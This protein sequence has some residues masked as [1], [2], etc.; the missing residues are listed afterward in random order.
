MSAI[1][2]EMEMELENELA[3]ERYEHETEAY[4]QEFETESELEGEFES[5]SENESEME[6][7]AF[8]NHLAA[9]ADR[10]GR[11]Q[12]LRRIGLAAARQALRSYRKS[13]PPAIEGEGEFE[14][15]FFEMEAEFNPL[16]AAHA[17]AVMEHLGHEAAAAETEE[18][19]AEQFLP[20]VPLA[21]KFVLPKVAK[22]AAKALPHLTK[23]V[24]PHLTRGVSQVARTL[25][26]SKATRPLLRTLPNISKRTV[27]HLARQAAHGRPVSP[28]AAVR[29]LARH[30]ARVLA[31]PR[32]AV[33]AFRRSKALDR[34]YHRAARPLLGRQIRP[35]A[36]PHRHRHSSRGYWTRPWRRHA[37][38]YRQPGHLQAGV[39]Q[40]AVPSPAV[41]SGQP[42]SVSY[43]GGPVG[44]LPATPVA[45]QCFQPV[46]CARC[47]HI[48]H[49]GY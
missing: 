39:H 26:R 34:R 16:Q 3:Q 43:V 2:S 45:C 4:E 28:K 24:L 35:R 13:P 48:Q 11:S 47:A 49:P 46:S 44:P 36:V 30:T 23:K 32:H 9:M 1:T 40:R 19:A 20:L 5:E 6:A 27:V 33:A 18:E 38:S 41:Y 25:F 29:T 21:A 12:A 31:N 8:F 17:N 14:D 42:G 10:G 22:F 7:E 15:E 37:V